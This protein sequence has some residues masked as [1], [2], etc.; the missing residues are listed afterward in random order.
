MRFKH[1]ITRKV[2]ASILLVVLVTP[3]AAEGSGSDKKQN[4][5]Q[6]NVVS[7]A[8]SISKDTSSLILRLMQGKAEIFKNF[9]DSAKEFEIQVIYTQIDR[10][11]RN[12]LSFRQFS[13]RLNDK[14]YYCPASTVK[15]PVSA[16]AMEKINSLKI[17]G[18]DKYSR[19][20]VDSAFACQEKVVVDTMFADSIPSIARY[21]EKIFL[22]SDNNSYN[23]LYEFLGQKDINVRLRKMGFKKTQI[24][25]RFNDCNADGNRYTNPVSFYS[26]G[27]ELLYSQPL[28]V[29]KEILKNPLG[30]IVKG[31]GII[32]DSGKFVPQPR[33]FTYYNNMP[34]QDLHD[35]LLRIMFPSAFKTKQKFNLT[36]DD[37]NYLYKYMCMYPREGDINYYKTNPKFV[38]NYKKYL[39][40]GDST[41]RQINDS[42]VKSFN[43]VGRASGYLTDCAYIVDFE[44]NI[45]FVLAAVIYTD[46]EGIFD[47]SYY[48]YKSLGL[49]FLQEL[50]KLIYEHDL[51]RQRKYKPDLSG[52]KKIIKY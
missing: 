13:Y 42:S 26:S 12:H 24:I 5:L 41:N 23:H 2:L 36:E 45:E 40:W 32:D 25:Q 29:N 1:I 35:I 6:K 9:I 39:L 7:A 33:D 43:I 47:Y 46:Q 3:L 44:N 28:V 10:D 38:D 34:L 15:L 4:M 30:E 19:M 48:R 37:Y 21:I 16:L 20:Q 17:K 18:L 31:K 14:E 27:G 8:Y 51:K 22:V 11:K 50:G 49:P 52:L